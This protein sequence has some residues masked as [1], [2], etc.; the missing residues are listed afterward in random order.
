MN[1]KQKIGLLGVL[2]CA[3][4]LL[5]KTKKEEKEASQ[6]R[7]YGSNEDSF[8][9]LSG[10]HIHQAMV[11]G[12][13]NPKSDYSQDLKTW[14][15]PSGVMDVSNGNE[16]SK[17]RKKKLRAFVSKAV[18]VQK[19]HRKSKPKS[20]PEVFKTQ[21]TLTNHGNTVRDI[22]LW[23]TNQGAS[24]SRPLPEDVDDHE[25]KQQ[26]HT[27]IHPQKVVFNPFNGLLYVTNQLS[28]SVSVLNTAGGLVKTVS[29][30][31]I[32]PGTLSPVDVA[33]DPSKG[34]AWVVC[35]VSNTVKVIDSSL[36]IIKTIPVG[37]RPTSIAFNPVNSSCYITNLYDHTISKID[38]STFDV[39]ATI[40]TGQGPR[41]ITVRSSDGS[42]WVSNSLSGTVSVY[43]TSDELIGEIDSDYP[44]EFAQT[45]KAVYL[46]SK[47]SNELQELDP[48]TF[49]IKNTYPLPFQPLGI[50]LNTLNGF[51][52]LSGKSSVY[53]Y[54][55]AGILKG[56][57]DL[58]NNRGISTLPSGEVYTITGNDLA[59]IG[60]KESSSQIT[61][62]ESYAEKKTEFQFKP[63][64]LNHAR[65]VFSDENRASGLKMA[66]HSPTGKQK[67]TPISFSS[68]KSPQSFL[69][70]AEVDAVK[71]DMID[72]KSAWEFK[73]A[74]L[75]TITILIYYKQLQFNHL[76]PKT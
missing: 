71:G 9:G 19:R 45:D 75:Q 57:I 26:I 2:A 7:L 54:T 40:K 76:L 73:I 69:D 46:L 32:F 47:N 60:Y 17:R 52:Y 72:G 55:T 59:Y 22:N 20:L 6:S 53:I 21:V 36:A 10:K 13:D 50:S 39:T 66:H 38:A 12:R 33:F 3:G 14:G 31:S 30:G 51:L 64:L 4:Y 62:N 29:L 18:E 48:D 41:G 67:T 5:F 44:T 58:K 61:I 34:N 56:N 68:Y 49:S 70:V 28:D 25:V 8:I 42:V 65:F 11:A 24:I 23:G 37:N 43:D 15:T 35:S 27:G 63:A 74:P 1:S 16:D